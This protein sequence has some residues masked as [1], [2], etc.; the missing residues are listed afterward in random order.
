MSCEQACFIG[1]I[2]R[3]TTKIRNLVS[4]FCVM[5]TDTILR[6][7][8]CNFKIKFVN[9][10][11]LLKFSKNPTTVD[12]HIIKHSKYKSLFNTGIRQSSV[13]ILKVTFHSRA[14]ISNLGHQT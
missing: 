7:L 1:F 9:Y 14:D 12:G 5:T 3:P 10:S 13:E 11:L 8:L 2:I 4:D 6:K